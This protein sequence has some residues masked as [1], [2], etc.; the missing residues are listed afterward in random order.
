[1]IGRLLGHTQIGTAQR[2]AHLID[3]RMFVGE[4]GGRGVE[5]KVEAM[6][7]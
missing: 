3:S 5:A 6:G 7:G 4:R 2:H 1:M